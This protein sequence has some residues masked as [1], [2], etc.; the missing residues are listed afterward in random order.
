MPLKTADFTADFDLAEVRI[1]GKKRADIFVQL[2]DAEYGFQF[3]I[4]SDSPPALIQVP[5][6][7]RDTHRI[8]GR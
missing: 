5:R 3:L 7:Q 4:Q 6:Q 2:A 8:V 1:G